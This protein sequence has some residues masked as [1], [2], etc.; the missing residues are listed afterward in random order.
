MSERLINCPPQLA[1]PLQ[2]ALFDEIAWATED[3]PTA[4]LRASY[5]LQRFLSLSR[6]YCDPAAAAPP[7]G[8]R[9]KMAEVCALFHCCWRASCFKLAVVFLVNPSRSQLA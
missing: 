4:E 2:Q 9:A 7:G 5:R 1:P 3:E 8:K 6:A